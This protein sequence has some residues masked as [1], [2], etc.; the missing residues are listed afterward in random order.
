[1]KLD[2]EIKVLCLDLKSDTKKIE[3]FIDLLEQ[4]KEDVVELDPDGDGVYRPWNLLLIDTI[5]GLSARKTFYASVLTNQIQP[6]V[7]LLLMGL[8][9]DKNSIELD[10]IFVN[11]KSLKH[12]FGHRKFKF[13]F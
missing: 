12:T 13:C 2:K 9:L 6:K 10:Q 4:H 8:S 11:R 3:S 5:E 1:M 7:I